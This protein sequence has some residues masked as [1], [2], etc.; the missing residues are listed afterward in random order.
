MSAFQAVSIHAEHSGLDYTGMVNAFR[1]LSTVG[2][3]VIGTYV[4][5][6]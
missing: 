2:Y 5:I 6:C 3:F 4:F 1:H